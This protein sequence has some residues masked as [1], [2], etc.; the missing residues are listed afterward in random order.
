[1]DLVLP[2]L[3]FLPDSARFAIA[4]GL[5][6]GVVVTA[7]YYLF[8]NAFQHAPLFALAKEELAA[9]IFSAIIIAFWIGSS[10]TI[11]PLVS[12]LVLPASPSG[13]QQNAQMSGMASSHVQLAL[14]SLDVL[15]HKLKETY[16]SMY[17]FEALI[18]FLS[19]ISFPLGSPVAGTAI[20]SFTLMPFD[21]LVL[22]SNA[23]TIVVETIGQLMTV[24]WA[25]EFILLFVRDVIP[26]IFF[27]LGLV[28][29]AIPFLRTTG[30]S[31]IAI[32]FAA[33]YVLPLSILLSNFLIFD[34]YKPADFVYMPENMGP[35]KTAITESGVE[36]TI[37]DSKNK[38]SEIAKIFK[39]DSVAKTAS[40][41]EECAGNGVVQMFC[42]A[43]LVI[44]GMMKAVGS[45]FKTMF[46]IWIFMMG[47]T[48][49]FFSGLGKFTTLTENPL[50]PS[51]ASAGLY[52][53]ILDSVVAHGQ[54]VAIVVITSLLE[55]I[56]T[57]TMYRNIA[58]IIGGEM[59]IAGLSKII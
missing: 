13:F 43:G 15:F 37:K 17:L 44:W 35:Y 20:I 24:I 23:H 45:F 25:K 4:A 55:I 10:I 12:A 2:L 22:L 39:A 18:G 27:P 50:L 59:E 29:R 52:F 28:F 49:D 46:D 31:I 11:D 38:S 6:L 3:L 48:G 51:S 5:G 26:I 7:L 40:T 54:F 56:F 33:Y 32:C 30:S 41:S 14:A 21:G 8:A 9:L 58:M 53:F 42:S 47:M 16:T 34:V 19:T 57:I 1:M 36:A